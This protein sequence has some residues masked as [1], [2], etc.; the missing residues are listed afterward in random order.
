[1]PRSAQEEEDKED[2]SAAIATAE[3]LKA[4]ISCQES[5]EIYDHDFWSDKVKHET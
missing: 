1:M 5:Q 2:K 4:R 3:S